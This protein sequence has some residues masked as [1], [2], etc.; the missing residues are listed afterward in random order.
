MT[1]R[2]AEAAAKVRNWGISVLRTAVPVAWGYILTWVA[3]NVPAVADIVADPRAQ[4]VSALI[5][6]AL[7][8]AWYALMR[9]LEPRL[10]GWFTVLVLGWNV[11]PK[12]TVFGVAYVPPVIPTQGDRL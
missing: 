10:P 11:A 3:T 6:G 5:T 4:A 2:T 9:W 12:Y 8:V 1:N 7:T